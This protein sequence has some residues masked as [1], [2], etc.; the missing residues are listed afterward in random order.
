MGTDGHALG[1]RNSSDSVAD[2]RDSYCA[3]AR[4]GPYCQRRSGDATGGFRSARRK[5][6]ARRRYE[7][8]NAQCAKFL[9]EWVSLALEPRQ[10]T[11]E[12]PSF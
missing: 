10:C 4:G 9:N 2:Q 7:V 8:I 12:L 5:R 6:R 1:Y 3:I 11:H